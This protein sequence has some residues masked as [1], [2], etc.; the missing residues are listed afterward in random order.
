MPLASDRPFEYI[1]LDYIELSP[2]EGKK[3]CLVVV[4]TF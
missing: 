3:Y 4:D 2:C 1:M